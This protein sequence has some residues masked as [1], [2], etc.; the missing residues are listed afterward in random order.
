MEAKVLTRATKQTIVN[1]LFEL[2]FG[3][4]R[5]LREIVTYQGT[6][7][8]SKL[9]QDIAYKYKIKYRKSTPYHPQANDQMESTKKTLEARMTKTVQM[10]RKYWLEKLHEALWAYRIT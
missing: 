7:F 1:F 8:T 10:H 3:R 4:F 5:V 9:V 2:I 6:N